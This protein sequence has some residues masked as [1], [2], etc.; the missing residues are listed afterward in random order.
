MINKNL[1]DKI[2]TQALNEIQFARTYKQNKISNWQKNED[3]YYG[4]KLTASESRAN[5]SLGRMQEFVH[6]LLSKID[7]QLVFKFVKRKESQLKR[8]N[9]LNALRQIDS[10]N[11]NWDI[12]DIA[13]KKQGIIYGRAIYSYYAD[14]LNGYKPHLE[15]VDVYDFLIDP[16]CGGIDID[17]AFYMGRYNIVKTK[18]DLKDGA[19]EGFYHKTQVANLI[20]GAGN[21]DEKSQEENNKK[22]RSYGV[23]TQGNKETVEENNKKFKFWEWYTTYEGI[24]YY[25]LMDN[26]GRWIRCEELKDL[27]ASNL[28]PFWTWAAFPDL[29]EFWTPSYCDYAREI[30]MAQDVSINQM[31]DNA[32]AINKPMKI[33]NVGA[34]ED[35]SRLKYRRDGIIPTKGDY[36]ANRAIQFVQTPSINTPIQVYNILEAIQEK[37]SG[38]TSGAK[39]VSDEDGKVGIYEG[40]QAAAAD[41]FNLLNKSL[42][43]GYKRFAKLYEWGVREHLIKKV[44]VDM[45]GPNGIETEEVTKRDL[46]KKGDDFLV[47][48]ETSNSE[49]VIS[50]QEQRL[51]MTF[52]SSQQANQ[53]V[54]QKKIFEMQANIVGFKEEEIKQ[55]LDTSEFGN[56]EIMSEA[57][58]DIES[59]LNGEDIKPNKNANNAYKQRLV[60]YLKD[61]EEDMSDE[62]FRRMAIY[63]DSLNTIIMQNEVR[64]LNNY[65]LNQLSNQSSE[66]ATQTDT[67]KIM[68]PSQEQTINSF[69]QSNYGEV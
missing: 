13:G 31:L 34:I 32:E 29:T 33:V 48:V 4:K 36:D 16:S 23:N 27:F 51:K 50:I 47:L 7:N 42:S 54:N 68:E 22:S 11:D 46:F 57:E 66:R 3:M 62:Q 28:W 37:A 45:I 18:K 44:A 14:S 17:P 25:I 21:A 69:N 12:K 60:D 20:E 55:L 1:A 49:N 30:F 6:T 5:V 61:H 38:V 35:L 43:F 40:N 39:G 9:R 65:L 52:L 59:I 64:S 58:R 26:R 63:I 67:L 41:R 15:S 19:K 8:V 56:Q 2:T 53:E 24:R 10:S